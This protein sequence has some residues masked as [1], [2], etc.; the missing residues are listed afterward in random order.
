MSPK[1]PINS[2]KYDTHHQPIDVR[3]Q[4]ERRFTLSNEKRWYQINKEVHSLKHNP[5]SINKY[6]T[7]MRCL[8]DELESVIINI[9]DEIRAF[10]GALNYNQK[11]GA[12]VIT[13][14]VVCRNSKKS[15]GKVENESATLLSRNDYLR[16]FQ[17]GHQGHLKDRCWIVIGYPSCLHIVSC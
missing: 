11:E 7:N 9:T 14:S 16:C 15:D 8:W 4:L 12:K 5:T 13:N 10:V 2:C 3:M 1:H 17:C 6:Y